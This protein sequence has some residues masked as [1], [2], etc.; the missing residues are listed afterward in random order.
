MLP[1][2]SIQN[3]K[4]TLTPIIEHTPLSFAPK[5][6]RLL[7]ANIFLTMSIQIA[8]RKIS[9]LPITAIKEYLAAFVTSLI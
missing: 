4:K 5:L 7:K 2:E 3:A 6:S 9:S 1:L 8:D